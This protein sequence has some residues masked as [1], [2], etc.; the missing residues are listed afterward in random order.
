MQSHET[1]YAAYVD[2]SFQTDIPAYGVVIIKHGRFHA[3]LCGIAKTNVEHHQIGGEITAV[4]EVLRWCKT[5]NVRAVTIFHDYE[6][7]EAWVTGRWQARKD[8]SQAYVKFVN[9]S[10]INITWCK[11]ES[12]TGVTWNEKAD[13]LARQAIELYHA[14]APD[15]TLSADAAGEALMREAEQVARA[16]AEYLTARGIQAE[17]KGLFNGMYARI[18]VLGGYFDLYNTRKK[19]LSP[20]IQRVSPE[21]KAQLEAAWQAFLAS[22]QP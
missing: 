10:G 4:I 15:S 21:A 3:A 20:K 16:F 14:M 18:S 17:F 19:R 6:G 5:H 9:D 8:L 1:E 11:V 2:G 22:R 7:L 13:E 12:H